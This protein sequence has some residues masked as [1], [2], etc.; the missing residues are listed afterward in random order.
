VRPRTFWQLPRSAPPAGR[1]C[2]ERR[3]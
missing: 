2:P 3:Q 1:G